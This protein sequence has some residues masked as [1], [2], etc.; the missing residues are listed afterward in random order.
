MSKD[1]SLV[2]KFNSIQREHRLIYMAK[3]GKISSK[4]YTELTSE[5][6]ALLVSRKYGEYVSFF[7]RRMKEVK[8]NFYFRYL[9][10][11]IKTLTI[12]DKLF[13]ENDFA[14]YR[15]PGNEIFLT[16]KHKFTSIYHELMHMA[17]YYKSDEGIHMGGFRQS[18]IFT[19]EIGR[20][21]NEGYTELLTR[22]Y[23]FDQDNDEAYN[24]LVDFAK[25]I[26]NII[27]KDKMEELYFNADLYNL[28][29]NIIKDTSEDEFMQF[30]EDSDWVYRYNKNLDKSEL[31]VRIKR[32]GNF[33]FLTY[34]KKQKRLFEEGRISFLEYN[35]RIDKTLFEMNNVYYNYGEID[36]WKC[37]KDKMKEKLENIGITVFCFSGNIYEEAEEKEEEEEEFGV[38]S[39]KYKYM[40]D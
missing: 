38:L 30:L 2:Q 13:L 6:K 25:S 31:T 26:E 39:K 9:E 3:T 22:R 34:L 8:P 33:V 24:V 5:E 19:I 21:L 17:S 40:K 15:N 12:K 4:N 18:K 16:Y 10:E 36:I 27:G 20:G 7:V 1:E 29:E 23:F 14:Q 35:F 37:E 32:M 11:N 28:K